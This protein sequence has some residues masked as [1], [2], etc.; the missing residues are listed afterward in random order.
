[1]EIDV[2]NLSV[3]SCI[4]SFPSVSFDT[5]A[6]SIPVVAEIGLPTPAISID[7]GQS[8]GIVIV[9]E[10]FIPVTDQK[11]PQDEVTATTIRLPDRVWLSVPVSG[12]Y[13]CRGTT[14]VV[15]DFSHAAVHVLRTLSGNSP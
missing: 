1:V 9:Y 12:V 7:P 2:R 14:P 3:Q 5:R 13:V 4:L 11:C 15:E 10:P 8:A 6:A